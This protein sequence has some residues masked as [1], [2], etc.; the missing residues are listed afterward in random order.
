MVNWIISMVN[1]LGTRGGI[2]RINLGRLRRRLTRATQVTTAIT[3]V[4]TIVVL[5]IGS[6]VVDGDILLVSTAI[7]WLAILAVGW[8][9]FTQQILDVFGLAWAADKAWSLFSAKGMAE[10][11]LRGAY[12]EFVRVVA[13]EGPD[14]DTLCDVVEDGSGSMCIDVIN[15]FGEDLAVFEGQLHRLCRPCAVGQWGGYMVGIVGGAVA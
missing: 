13:E 2:S 11:A 10:A 12:G 15:L 9:G 14:S 6:T 8:W 4:L 1:A 3:A 7:A 5:V